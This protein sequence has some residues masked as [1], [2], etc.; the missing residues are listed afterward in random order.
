MFQRDYLQALVELGERDA[1]AQMDRIDTFL[2]ASAAQPAVEQRGS[3][4][5][6]PQT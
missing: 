3:I 1:E 4:P 6:L 2:E 5:D